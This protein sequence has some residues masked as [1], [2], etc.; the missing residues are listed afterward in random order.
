MASLVAV[1]V[2]D[3]IEKLG[4]AQT[5]FMDFTVEKILMLGWKPMTSL[6]SMYKGMIRGID[7]V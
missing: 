3:D 2:A 4:Y 1:D 5:L 7:N 6:K